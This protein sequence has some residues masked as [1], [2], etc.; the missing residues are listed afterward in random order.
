MVKIFR[1]I[2]QC[3]GCSTEFE[4][5]DKVRIFK[6][7]VRN[8]NE[9]IQYIQSE[10]MYCL[11]CLPLALDFENSYPETTQIVKPENDL[12]E[13]PIE[14]KMIELETD[15]ND[16]S[17]QHNMI[18]DTIRNH[19]NLIKLH[20]NKL[21]EIETSVKYQLNDGP[22]SLED[23]VLREEAKHFV[24]SI[25][26]TDKSGEKLLPEFIKSIIESKEDLEKIS[27]GQL[28][29]T[30]MGYKPKESIME[31]LPKDWP[32]PS[33]LV[34]VEETQTSSQEPDTIQENDKSETI[35]D[36]F[37]TFGE[38][39]GKYL[40]LKQIDNEITET[41]FARK[42]NYIDVKDLRIACGRNSLVGLYYSTNK[43][44]DDHNLEGPYNIKYKPTKDI[45]NKMFFGVPNIVKRNLFVYD[46]LGIALIEK[47]LFED[48][49]EPATYVIPEVLK[50]VELQEIANVYPPVEKEIL[51]KQAKRSDGYERQ[52]RNLESLSKQA[53]KTGQPIIT[54][55]QKPPK[56]Q[57]SKNMGDDYL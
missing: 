19:S 34:G 24:K 11:N 40:I 54:G 26:I 44:V 5:A 23:Q 25:S 12:A 42:N 3:D 27:Q 49:I 14:S 18:I 7:I 31:E 9:S 36:E 53:Q 8:G 29:H 48:S 46:N 50:N 17:K 52:V 45:I 39:T 51:E 33:E 47:D 22:E 43:F 38:T 6:G 13:P 32:N 2:Y 35:E 1:P 56:K 21:L 20:D 57:F 4:D 16:L 55:F 28:H 30:K 37:D 41:K 10:Q 15:I